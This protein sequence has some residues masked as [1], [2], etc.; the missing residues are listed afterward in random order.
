MPNVDGATRASAVYGSA[1]LAASLFH[2]QT[3]KVGFNSNEAFNRNQSKK[4]I[5]VG[6]LD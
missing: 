4:A 6:T 2:F 1:K 5:V 3:W